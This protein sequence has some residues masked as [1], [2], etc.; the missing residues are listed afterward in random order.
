MRVTPI[1]LTF[2]LVFG[3]VN[4][5]QSASIESNAKEVLLVD[6]KTGTVLFE[7]NADAPMPP[8]SMSKMM[9]LYMLFDL[10][11]QG[12]VKLDDTLPV[13]EKAWRM[14]GSKM[15]VKVGDRVRIEDLIRGIIVHS[16]NDACI[17]VAEGLG[18]SEEAFSA[19]ITKRAREIGMRSSDF[20]N[21]T[22]WPDPNHLT[23]ARDLSTLA[24]RTIIDHPEFYRYYG[25]TSFTFSRITQPNRNPLLGRVS[26]ADG[27]K[28]G[29]TEA[30]G[31][32]LTA[33]AARDGRRL[34]L[35]VNGLNSMKSRGEESERLMEW[36]FRE[37]NNY[38]LFK[39]GDAVTDVPVWLGDQG[40]LSLV[41]QQ[42]LEITLPRAARANMK[43]TAVLQSPV[44]AP[45]RKGQPVGTLVIS[46]PGVATIERPLYAG[47]DIGELGL[48]GRLTSALRYILWGVSG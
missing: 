17:V 33:S 29:H 44:P 13:S 11:K 8:S 14:G 2:L 5:V 15:F 16:G 18:G 3:L 31:Y 12:R 27:L 25:E 48:L 39:P 32:G 20:R 40:T 23:T 1:L 22:G 24:R 38:L 36:G 41:V 37:F 10:I 19:E 7:K 45:I 6:F 43:V 21:A 42:P 26:G 28:T 9:T 30:A 34:I 47:E 46:A 35:V 4:Q